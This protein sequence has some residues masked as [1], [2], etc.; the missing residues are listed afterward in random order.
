M[1]AEKKHLMIA[2]HPALDLLNTVLIEDGIKVDRLKHDDNVTAWLKQAGFLSQPAHPLRAGKLLAAAQ[3]LRETI[4]SVVKE[5]KQGRP[6]HTE[7]LNRF[8]A[9]SRKYFVLTQHRGQQPNLETKFS[10]G[11]EMEL[12]APVAEA[13]A[14]LIV[15]ADFD[16]VRQCE[17]P[18]CILWFLD[19]T[20]A[21]RRRWCSMAVCGNRQKVEAFRKR[22]KIEAAL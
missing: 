10:A 22:A 2:D 20:K 17:H 12:L 7:H 19:T 16:L 13:A 11:D 15:H 14:E 1:P 5:R 9:R 6:V 4:Q 18:S 8:L 21:H 3:N